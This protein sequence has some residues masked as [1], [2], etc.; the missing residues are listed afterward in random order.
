MSVVRREERED[1]NIS[2]GTVHFFF[3]ISMTIMLIIRI[4]VLFI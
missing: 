3:I 1:N 4:C 2:V